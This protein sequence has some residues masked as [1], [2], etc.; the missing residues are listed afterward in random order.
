M[1]KRLIS[2]EIFNHPVLMKMPLSATLLWIGL[3][4]ETD[5][6]GRVCVDPV[7]LR[8]RLFN[9]RPRPSV[10]DCLR[11]LDA[12]VADDMLKT[13]IR[14]D[15]KYAQITNFHSYQRLKKTTTNRE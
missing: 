12:F 7:W 1:P 5:G 14:H 11:Y 6:D 8:R 15:V 10:A 3:I 4:V 9:S 2:S 13:Y